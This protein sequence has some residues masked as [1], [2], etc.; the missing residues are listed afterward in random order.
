VKPLKP[1]TILL[2]GP[3]LLA[4]AVMVVAV[5]VNPALRTPRGGWIG[6]VVGAALGLIIFVPLAAGRA[7]PPQFVRRHFES[8][9][10]WSS[11]L[12]AMGLG[13][14]LFAGMGN[15]GLLIAFSV[16]FLSASFRAY[17]SMLTRRP[18]A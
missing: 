6:L 11:V 2:L 8:L 5:T 15:N 13:H 1:L 17:L 7:R 14:W 18:T 10:R 9:E 16:L 4:L 3:A 12:L